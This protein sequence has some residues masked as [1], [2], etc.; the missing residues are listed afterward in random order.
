LPRRSA[1]G[2]RG[3]RRSESN[4]SSD[5]LA[6]LL[7]SVGAILAAEALVVALLIKPP[8]IGWVGF[9][10]VA[11]IVLALA[12]LIPIALQV[13]PRSRRRSS[14]P[15][16]STYR[17][18]SCASAAAPPASLAG[19]STSGGSPK[20]MERARR[21]L[22]RALRIATIAEVRAEA[23]ILEGS[24]KRRIIEFARHR[25]A[26]LVVVGSR[27]RRLGRGVACAVAPI[28]VAERPIV[29]AA[30]RKVT[31]AASPMATVPR[32]GSTSK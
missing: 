31:R 8:P 30:P 29:V 23:E 5:Q 7:I 13:V 6:F 17:W 9:A 26:D 3:Q 19:P 27:P 28:V 14:S 10:V 32:S 16:N 22:D 2:C 25:R 1:G 12:A 20:E 21:V 18:C 24:P 15:P 4:A 11:A